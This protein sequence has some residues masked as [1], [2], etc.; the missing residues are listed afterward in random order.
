MSTGINVN[1]GDKDFIFDIEKI[2]NYNKIIYSSNNNF[3][4]NFDL[5][6]LNTENILN[7]Y[8]TIYNWISTF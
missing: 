2:I 3:I 6:K 8:E 1:F 5:D 7:N 4:T